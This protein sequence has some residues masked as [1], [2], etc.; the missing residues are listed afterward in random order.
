MM[1]HITRAGL[2][3][4]NRWSGSLKSYNGLCSL[5]EHNPTRWEF[6][7]GRGFSSKATQ[8][9]ALTDFAERLQ[10][11]LKSNSA[12]SSNTK[13]LMTKELLGAAGISVPFRGQRTGESIVRFRSP[14][15]LTG[16][17][18][19][20]IEGPCFARTF[21]ST[22]S[23]QGR[24]K[25]SEETR[26]DISTIEDPFDSPTYNIPEKPV[27]FTE[28]ASYS[29]IILAG[30][31]IAAAAAY[32]VFKELI[33]EPKEYKIFGK[34]LERI[35]NDS[36]VRVR[37]GTPITGYGQESRNRAARQRIPHRTWTDEDGVEH[38]EVNFYIRGPHGAGKVYTEMFKDK[39]DKLWKFTYLIVEINSPSPAQLMLESYVPA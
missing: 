6:D 28:G 16:S 17:H 4:K 26:K 7:L 30:L 33:F 32:A 37:I 11:V 1:H 39:V 10:A 22:A 31:G 5:V 36:Q 23:E 29:V 38:V 25:S 15:Q 3:I 13:E 19:A 20:N 12:R 27:T 9:T 8:R 24:Q 2:L 34:A 35:Q 14:F 18:R 21:A